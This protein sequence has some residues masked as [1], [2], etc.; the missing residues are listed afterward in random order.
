MTIDITFI[1]Y[2]R[3]FR[4]YRGIQ[5]I[6]AS[7]FKKTPQKITTKVL[8]FNISS[9][10][11]NVSLNS[12][13]SHLMSLML[14]ASGCDVKYIKCN[15]SIL[16]CINGVNADNPRKNPPCNYCINYKNHLMPNAKSILLEN[17]YNKLEDLKTILLSYNIE[18]LLN[19][20]YDKINLGQLVTPSVRWALRKYSLS[21]GDIDKN[22]FVDYILSSINLL[23]QFR[24]ILEEEKPNCVVIFNGTSY[25]EALLHHV[26]CEKNIDVI[27][28]E[29]GYSPK[30]LFITRN[31]A[32]TWDLNIP[33][34]F[35]MNQQEDDKLDIY[36]KNRFGGNFTMSGVKF[37][38]DI[39]GIPSKL[40]HKLKCYDSVFSVFTNVIFDT[41]QVHANSLY[42]NMFEWLDELAEF[43]KSKSNSMFIIRA[44]PDESRS[45][46]RSRESVSMWYRSN[47]IS[48]IKNIYFIPPE[49][50][51]S[52][53]ELINLSNACLV[54][55]STIGLEA[56]ILG[57]PVICAGNSRYRKF[58]IGYYYENRDLYFDA[59]NKIINKTFIH[60]NETQINN[61][62]R[63]MYYTT[64][65]ASID[66]SSYIK[67]LREYDY[68]FKDFDLNL[69]LP[70]YSTEAKIIYDGI[71]KNKDF[72]YQ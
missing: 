40:K 52:S 46:K 50:Y 9:G 15:K 42:S 51:A 41:S 21:N 43:A 59:I 17:E 34:S 56:A 62:R 37:W 23:P 16:K 67:P 24:K 4:R 47:Q 68:T 33:T 25:A 53:Y 44:H 69:L 5:R 1:N 32:T 14:I 20:T 29:S 71:V 60:E 63:Y 6:N 12:V 70:E 31:I 2:V 39:Q 13:A 49:N 45:G 27:T 48:S 19:Y 8:F 61:A 36:L 28:Y 57:K 72:A 38:K 58:Q 11:T 3:S 7:I 18:Q 64:F 66:F 30:S 35:S 22:L 65:K 55:N 54:Y 26:A 10:T